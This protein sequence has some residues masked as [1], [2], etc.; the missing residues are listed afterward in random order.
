MTF[1]HGMVE[2]Q[3]CGNKTCTCDVRDIRDLRD[4]TPMGEMI[5]RGTKANGCPATEIAY[6]FDAIIFADYS[7]SDSLGE[8]T[9]SQYRQ[10][11]QR[12]AAQGDLASVRVLIEKG[13]EVPSD[14]P[15]SIAA[16]AYEM[17]HEITCGCD[18]RVDPGNRRPWHPGNNH[19]GNVDRV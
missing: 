1:M 6:N 13:W 4:P 17:M 5:L 15:P 14:L 2:C 9:V 19:P 11:M 10:K 3:S 16:R 8:S 7:H 18:G 12:Q